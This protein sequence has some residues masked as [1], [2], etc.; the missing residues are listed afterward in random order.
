MLQ[1]VITFQA[2]HCVF[3]LQ[4]SM[5]L[6]HA[7]CSPAAAAVGVRAVTWG[8]PGGVLWGVPSWGAQPG[9]LVAV[10]VEVCVQLY[11]DTCGCGCGRVL[12]SSSC[13]QLPVH[14]GAAGQWQ[15]TVAQWTMLH[16]C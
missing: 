5:L 12:Q 10:G 11:C 7:L 1:A 4:H 14:V 16:V 9:L 2:G 6:L 13:F 15:G 8:V 3:L